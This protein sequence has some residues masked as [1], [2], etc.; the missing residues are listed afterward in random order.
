MDLKSW[1]ER[2]VGIGVANSTAPTTQIVELGQFE[3]WG[4]LLGHSG[5]TRH[6][7]PDEA[8]RH[9]AVYACVRLIAGSIAML[10]LHSYFKQGDGDR[11]RLASRMAT[12]LRNRPNPRMSA[13][14]FWRHVVSQMLLRGN[15]YGYIQRS[16]EGEVL[17]IWPI[18]TGSMAVKIGST[19]S[20]R[21]RLIYEFDLDD[22]THLI[23][24][25]DDVLHF[26]G[27]MEWNGL[28]AKTPIRAYADAVAVGLAA[29]DYGRR[30]FENDA[31][32]QGYIG[33]PEN[34][35]VTSEQ[36]K[37]IRE[38]WSEMNGGANRHMPA[39]LSSGAKWQQTGI[40]AEDAQLLETRGFQ[41]VDVARVF[42]VP[43]HMIGAVDKTTSWGSGIEEQTT[44][45]I[46]YTLG[47]HLAAIEQEVN[48]KIHRLSGTYSEFE[49]RALVQALLKER[50]EAYRIALGG[51][52]GPGYMTQNEVRRAEN[53]PAV[54]GGD[55]LATWDRPSSSQSN[56]GDQNP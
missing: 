53:L 15:G 50:N 14:M 41:V 19:Q 22:G 36:A 52:S 4:D 6:V 26:P 28:E 42:G 35:K 3:T 9:S 2:K 44:G 5:Y 38:Y 45:F 17:A 10:P 20:L 48:Y 56:S 39:V 29:N 34:T 47:Q 1:F 40:S 21:G 31:T 32:P 49:R 25:Q 37:V 11:Q 13:V 43:P 30:F 27:T 23:A 33:Y 18:R 54:P 16:R 51:S 24:D 8:M 12:L 7:S 55:T 46:T